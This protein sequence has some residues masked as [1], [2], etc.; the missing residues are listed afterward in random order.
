M[1]KFLHYEVLKIKEEGYL[2]KDC[3]VAERQDLTLGKH[4]RK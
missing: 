2:E 3:G 4:M 1:K